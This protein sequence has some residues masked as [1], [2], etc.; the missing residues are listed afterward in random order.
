MKNATLSFSVKK[1]R[2]VWRGKLQP[3]GRDKI[4]LDDL[5]NPHFF[6]L[7]FPIPGVVHLWICSSF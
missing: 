3:S 1:I 2:M 4:R 7:L 6:A 5:F